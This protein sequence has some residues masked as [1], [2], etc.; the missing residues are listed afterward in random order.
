MPLADSPFVD[1][2]YTNYIP[3]DSD[4][5]EIRALLVDPTDELA[6][7]CSIEEMEIALSQL[8]EQHALPDDVLRE[9]FHFCLP[10]EHNMLIDP[11]EAPMLLGRICRHWRSVTLYPEYLELTSYRPVRLS[12][13]APQYSREVRESYRE[14]A[15]TFR[16]LSLSISFLDH[17]DPFDLSN[18]PAQNHPIYSKLLSVIRRLRHIAISGEAA[19]LG[20]FL[21]LRSKDLPLL[22]TLR[23]YN[24]RGEM[25]DGHPEHTNT[26]QLP[27]LADLSLSFSEGADPLSL[28]VRWS[29]LTGLT[30]MCQHVWAGNGPMGGLD[31]G[32][33]LDVLR[34]FSDVAALA[35]VKARIAMPSSLQIFQAQF[36]RPMEVDIIPEL[37]PLIADGL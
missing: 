29:Q 18:P 35:F 2:L 28:P 36:Y 7:R 21:R 12:T 5:S 37:Q 30:L 14:V 4:L 25:F 3:S 9:I 34:R 15:R 17:F 8:K 10:S 32:G 11:D 31:V 13:S 19:V 23:I 20:H 26:L 6:H 22:T 27:T 16:Q 24:N 33:V 1:R